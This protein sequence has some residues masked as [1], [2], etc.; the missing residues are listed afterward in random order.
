[1]KLLD[2][3]IIVSFI[4]NYLISFFVLVG[5]Y[6]VLDMVIQFDE[7]SK[8]Q[9]GDVGAEAGSVM[10]LAYLLADFYLHQTAL[11]FV[12]LAGIIPGVAASFTLLRMTRSN[13][14]TAILAA[15]VP[16][17]RVAAPIILIAVILSSLVVI[18]Q[19]LVIPNIISELTRRHDQ[20]RATS[21]ATYPIPAMQ[22]NTGAIL[23]ATR[24]RPPFREKAAAMDIV[25][26]IERD[27]DSQPLGHVYADA[28]QWDSQHEQWNLTNGRRVTGLKPDERPKPAVPAAAY[29]SNINP[30]EIAL[31]H[32]GD[33]IDLLS[34]HRINKLLDPSRRNSYGAAGLLRVKHTRVTQWIMNIVLL[35]LGI[36]AVLTREPNALRSAAIKCLTLSG[37][38]LGTIFLC[39]SLAGQAPP[40]AEWTRV[41]PALTAW[42]PVFLFGPLSVW[43]LDRVKT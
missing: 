38:C 5:L 12:H 32:S 33:F 18:D 28:A 26:I 10:T 23:I 17:G 7:I 4:K 29:K 6:I 8:L 20:L 16:L 19:E 35:L 2:R 13:E 22:D 24:Y 34:I 25:D 42:M 15:G 39:N 27:A 1:M 41:W 43:L 30:D 11:F 31:F 37:L 3:Y 21:A 9:R 14:L 40:S 36:P